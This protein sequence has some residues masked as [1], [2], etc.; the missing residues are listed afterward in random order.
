MIDGH[1][2]RTRPPQPSASH[3]GFAAAPLCPRFSS[4]RSATAVT[5]V[6]KSEAYL[7]MI[8][9]VAPHWTH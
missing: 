8:V 6:D 3:F 9:I 7:A 4:D 1:A 5:N 2:N